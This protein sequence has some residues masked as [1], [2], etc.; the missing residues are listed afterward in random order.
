MQLLGIENRAAAVENSVEGSENIKPDINI[1][2]G[3]S[4]SGYKAIR[5]EGRD[6]MKYL[7]IHVHSSIFH[8]SQRVEET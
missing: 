2:S 5:I 6:L 7:H 3:N 8:N 1:W 4:I